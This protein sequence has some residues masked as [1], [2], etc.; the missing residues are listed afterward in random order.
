MD[1]MQFLLQMLLL[2]VIVT[3]LFFALLC[4][5]MGPRV[6]SLAALSHVVLTAM[7]AWLTSGSLIDRGDLGDGITESSA[8][9]PTFEPS[10]VPGDPGLAKA[11][12]AQS[13]FTTWGLLSL[14]E[15][16]GR[17]ASPE[18]QLYF[19][20][21]GLNIWLIVLTSVMTLVAVLISA[22]RVKENPSGYF[23]WLF[24]LQTAVIGAFA[25]FDVI[26]FYVFF[27]LTLIPSFFLIGNWGTGRARRDAAKLFFLYTL[28][29]SL[30]TLV[31]LIGIVLQNPTPVIEQTTQGPEPTF[32][33][34]QGPLLDPGTG[35]YKYPVEG[36]ITFSIPRL[37]QNVN[38]WANCRQ[39]KVNVAEQ[40]IKDTESKLAQA[41][42]LV[43]QNPAN[44]EAVAQASSLRNT[45]V[46]QSDELKAAQSERSKAA[47]WEFWLFLALMAGFAVK[48]PFVPFHTWLPTAYNEAPI[49]VTMLLSAVLAKLG[50]YGILRVV[51]TL[52]PEAAVQHGPMIFGSMGAVGI[53]YGAFCAFAQKDM[54]LLTAYSSISHLGLLG[55][56]L[57][58]FNTESLTGSALHMVNHG[59]ATGAM[60]ALLGFLYHRYRTLEMSQ[61][62]GLLGKYPAF[63]FLFIVVSLANVGL[64]FLNNF[65]SEMM[66]LAGLSDPS[67]TKSSGWLFVFV[68]ASG[69]FLSAWYTFT[70]IRKVFFGPL[71]LPTAEPDMKP[72]MKTPEAFGYILPLVLC[73][74]LGLAPQ[75]VVNTMKGDVATLVRHSNSARNRLGL[76]ATGAYFKPEVAPSMAP[77]VVPTPQT[78]PKNAPKNAPKK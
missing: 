27:E 76:P 38:T 14:G 9:N 64:P 55:L 7:L 5:V 26:L 45:L 65:V 23:A 28:F 43:K 2:A 62:G 17:L 25:S 52:V 33:Q 63:A 72:G 35:R 58:A 47:N 18:I 37:M 36:P 4:A 75:F 40:A 74:V 60:F 13:H 57:F 73:F 42:T 44:L 41:E 32:S 10:F 56:G 21:D 22:G 39:W 66:I 48:V 11:T 49:A 46:T 19:G 24:V 78:M 16:K 31:G 20:I 68:A 71:L 34:Q 15:K 30:F 70:M 29:G 53:V 59:L 12:E 61:F 54:K 77:G 3:P 67:V 50:T 6:A 8:A 51:L 1:N 69:I